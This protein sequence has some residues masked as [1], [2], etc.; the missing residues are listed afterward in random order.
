MKAFL[1]KINKDW[2]DDFVYISRYPLESRGYTI[3][4]FNGE[5][6]NRSMR[7]FDVDP[8]NDICI[9][10]VEATM[11][12]FEKCGVPTPKYLGY[13]SELTKYL[14]RVIQKKTFGELGDNYPYFIKPADDVKL[15]TGDIV[16][17]EKGKNIFKTYCDI[18][19]CTLV[20]ESSIVDFISE[21]RVFVS[22]GEIRGIKHYRGDF[23]RFIDVN[24]VYNMISEFKD[25]PSAYTLDVGLVHDDKT[26]LVEVNDMWAIG[27]YGLDGNTYSLL[28]ARR[29]K[30]ILKKKHI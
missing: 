17:D 12:F 22:H 5:D 7:I 8:E 1:E 2:L 16:R 28:C 19:D 23:T 24:L 21:Y 25:C 30:E 20:Y 18:K 29:M 11:C 15:F 6:L 3:V 14:G 10:S 26:L 9:G 4:P 27:S 13:P